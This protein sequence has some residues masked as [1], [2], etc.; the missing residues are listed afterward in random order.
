MSVNFYP[1]RELL[2]KEVERCVSAGRLDTLLSLC[3]SCVFKMFPKRIEP[4]CQSCR[5]QYGIAQLIQGM[6]SR[7]SGR[8]DGLRAC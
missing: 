7:A 1:F 3:K 4:E 5:I 8:E 2:A 6:N